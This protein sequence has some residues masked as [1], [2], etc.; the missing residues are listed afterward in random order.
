V[1]GVRIHGRADRIDQLPDGTLAVVDYKTGTPPS[2][3]MV[4]EGFALQL[5]LIGL[6]AQGG[7]DQG[8][9]G[10]PARFE[11]WSLARNR[12]AISASWRSPCW[13]AAA[14]PASRARIPRPPR[15]I[16]E[17]AIARWMLG[18]DPFTARLNPDLPGYSDY[19]Q[20]MRLDEW[21]GRGR[22]GDRP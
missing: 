8:R 16:L 21:Q 6:I 7:L 22:A 17:E 14:S 5:G 15:E 12:G 11:Y 3:R 13:K 20:L 4:E 10:K 18:R 2:A 19:D 1:D 9:G